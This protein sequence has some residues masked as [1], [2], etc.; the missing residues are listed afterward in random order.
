MSGGW[1]RYGETVTRAVV[2]R[3]APP[4]SGTSGSWL[5]GR[6]NQARPRRLRGL[7]TL[8]A[9]RPLCFRAAQPEPPAP[10]GLDVHT[11]PNDWPGHQ[12]RVG[13][14]RWRCG[15]DA[16]NRVVQI[17]PD[18]PASGIVQTYADDSRFSR[19]HGR[20]WQHFEGQGSI[21]ILHCRRSQLVD[22]G[23]QTRNLHRTG[24]VV[25]NEK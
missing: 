17:Q 24:W 10:A 8:R 11:A 23:H 2:D 22:R 3:A 1:R 20:R 16:K 7:R 18:R 14:R 25:G 19:G 5:A 21:R 6:A 13:R 4:I 9:P 15:F 12:I